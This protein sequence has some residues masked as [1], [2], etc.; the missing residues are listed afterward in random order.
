MYLSLL[1]NFTLTS[2]VTGV[3]KVTSPCHQRLNS[4]AVSGEKCHTFELCVTGA[5]EVCVWR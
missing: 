3:R 4:S 1:R 5:W 2:C